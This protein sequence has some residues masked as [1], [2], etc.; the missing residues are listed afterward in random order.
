MAIKITPS[1]Y[2]KKYCIRLVLVLSLLIFSSSSQAYRRVASV[3]LSGHWEFVT[4]EP[5]TEQNIKR[6][7]SFDP[8]RYSPDLEEII[9]ISLRS[10]VNKLIS[11]TPDWKIIQVPSAWE[12]FTSIQYNGAGWYRRSINI[13]VNWGNDNQNIWIEFDAVATATGV[14]LNG[15]W[16]GGHV[17]DYVR[18]RVDATD[19]FKIGKNELLVYVDELPGHIT[20]GFLSVIAP[21][22][23]GIWQDVR[24]Y[25]T[26]RV[27]VEPDG[28]RIVTNQENGDVEVTVT[29]NGKLPP[30]S[31]QPHI[32]VGKYDPKFPQQIREKN[33][34][35]K[36]NYKYQNNPD[37]R[38]ISFHY[39]LHDFQIWHPEDPNLYVAEVDL[40]GR[41][42]SAG[43]ENII[44]TFAFR[45]IEI[46]AEQV[47]LNGKPLNIRS[48]LNWG[49][50]P[51]IVSPA[52]PVEVIREE[53]LKYKQ[54]GFNAET[55]CLMIMP[56]YFYDLAD[57]I[58]ILIWEEYPT[59]HNEF[60]QQD[61]IT[62]RR[63]F[64]AY[65]RRDQ[66]HPSIILRSISVEAGV[67]DQE[68]M[69][70]LVKLAR[71]M[72]DSPIQD[73]SSWFWLSNENL[74]EWY[75]EDNYWNHNRWARHMLIDL[76]KKLDEMPIKP[77][78]IGESMA[79]S[80][81]P[82][83][84]ALLAV[85]PDKPLANGVMGTDESLA[86]KKWPYWFPSCFE[87]CREIEE[88]LRQ[89]YQSILPEGKDIIRDYL[90]PQSY[91]YSEEF[92]RFQIELLYSDPRYAGWTFFLGRDVAQC[93][94]G[95]FDNI[96]RLRWNPENWQ[97]LKSD[98]KPKVTTA[99][100]SNRNL[101]RSLLE[102]A[103]ELKFWSEKWDM[104]TQNTLPCYYLGGGYSDLSSLFSNWPHAIQ[105]SEDEIQNLPLN[106]IIVTTIL[107]EKLSDYMIKGG[108]VFIISSRWPGAVGSQRNMYWA[109]AVFIPPVGPL[110]PENR[111]RL[112]TLQMFDLTHGKS[113]V[114]PVQQLNIH[115]EVDPLLRLF[116]IH[117]LDTVKIHDQIFATRCG[118]GLLIASSLDHNGQAGQWLLGE[119][120][121]WGHNWHETNSDNFPATQMTPEIL[122]KLSVAR[123]NDIIV[124][125][126]N[127]RFKTDPE[128]QGEKNNWTDPTFSDGEWDLIEAS[129]MWESQGYSY[130]GMAWYRKWIEVSRDWKGR[131]I[132]LVA[133][134]VD[135]AY[136]LWINGKA[137][138][139]YGSFT[140]HS[141]TV[142][143]T[144]TETDLTPYLD[145]GTRNLLVLQVVD[146]FGG[147]GIT[148]PIYLRVE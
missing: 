8:P 130:D 140:D 67:K 117:G 1:I 25:Q 6:T 95:L 143:R 119:L 65:F 120:L 73:N 98:L 127:W 141:K 63:E 36:H 41:D 5:L 126:D 93:H 122:S 48:V 40:P 9:P 110:S 60:T 88:S 94:S 58:G 64:P 17:G 83:V 2:S 128:E 69:A 80:V 13:P 45:K 76:P 142:F 28:I 86:G 34:L 74:T 129:K 61:M 90:L 50:Y 11:S 75:G 123:I 14:W 121:Y 23:G 44:Q 56:D 91:R 106:S 46:Q 109:D 4:T 10:D 54:M 62:Y 68:V 26:G 78:I 103:P 33:L 71:Q 111:N 53:F 97:W 37:E 49:Y 102:I 139:F 57:E 3:S 96:G 145:Y 131:K 144:K 79:G 52:P 114:I 42:N 125:T 148:Q 113:E 18:W 84:D 118:K 108:R 112:L 124:L 19:A 92:R 82:D 38:E 147:G 101:N 100:M 107:T 15:E 105:I 66:N 51:R 115:T 30:D 22:H 136:Q 20:Q 134:G 137:V 85:H 132:S 16:L 35:K 81:W 133:E 116:E 87:S 89:R 43:S 29:L 39:K 27:S 21:H 146:V 12:Q 70:E 7:G 138:A 104:E 24:L 55:I 135:D 31:P 99:Q 47:L 59:W 77:Y 72:T 32:K